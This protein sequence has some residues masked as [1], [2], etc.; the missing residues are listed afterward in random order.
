MIVQGRLLV[1]PDHPPELGWMRINPATTHAAASIAS[2]A[3]GELPADLTPPAHGARDRIICPAF[4][5]AHFHVPQVDTVGCDGMPLL[6]WLDQVV[7]PAEAWW[8]RGGALRDTRTA[9]RRLITQGTSLVAAYLTAHAEGSR[10]AAAF[11]AN[12][13]PLRFIA[14]RV[15]MDRAAPEALTAEDITRA[16]MAPPPSPILPSVSN[17]PRHR[18]SANPRF[19]ISCTPE[20]LAE[21]GWAVKDRPEVIVQ[22]HLAETAEECAEVRKLFPGSPPYTAVYDEAGLLRPGT[23]LAHC[24]HLSDEEL[25]LIRQRASIA[26]HCPTA[27]TFLQAGLFDL[28]RTADDFGVAVALGSDVAGGPDVAMPRVARGMIEV[29]KMLRMTRSGS[30]ARRVKVPTPAEAWTMITRRNADL[31]GAPKS[32]RLEE[33]AEADLL[34]MRIPEVWFDEHLVGRLLYNWSPDLVE[35]R[36]M[37][38]IV[39][40]PSS[41]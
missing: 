13:T 25:D 2:I 17:S 6:E 28:A 15:A 31:L 10:E 14:G 37:N 3:Y 11:L 20:L 5:D 4:A 22:T 35:T 1:D 12:R 34:V 18:I 19:A 39:V 26:V 21:V 33:G 9:A 29:A 8:G 23:L 27:N 41:I 16:R 7:F 24:I 32:C 38:G 40:N 36:I 30:A